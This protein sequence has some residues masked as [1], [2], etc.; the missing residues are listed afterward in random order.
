V[1]LSAGSSSDDFRSCASFT[2]TGATRT[3]S[4]N[5]RVFLSTTIVGPS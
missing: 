1:E 3:V 5:E 4:G 2:V